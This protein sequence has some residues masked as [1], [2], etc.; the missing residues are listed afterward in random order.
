MRNLATCWEVD[1]PYSHLPQ[2]PCHSAPCSARLT[3]ANMTDPPSAAI[4]H[5]STTSTACQADA[6]AIRHLTVRPCGIAEF[7]KQPAACLTLASFLASNTGDVARRHIRNEELLRFID[8][9]CFC[10][11]TVLAAQ[12]PMI[13][14][15]M[16]FC[17]RHYGGINYPVGGVGRIPEALADGLRELGSYLVYK[18][19][20]RAV[21]QT[22]I[23]AHHTC[24]LSDSCI[25][26]LTGFPRTPFLPQDVRKWLM[27]H[28]DTEL[29][30]HR[31]KWI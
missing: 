10:W 19:N 15:G 6:Q 16:V 7:A 8:I 31:G 13:N 14:A 4:K 12:T 29:A 21:C 22:S 26:L 17:D 9:E 24:H 5:S 28:V 23:A 18:A 27:I 2:A 20:V 11:S 25:H 30:R 3:H 1:P